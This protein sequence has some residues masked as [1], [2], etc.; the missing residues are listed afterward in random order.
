MAKDETPDGLTD[1][2]TEGEDF[3]AGYPGG[4]LLVDARGAV[5]ATNSKGAAIEALLRRGE[6]EEIADLI[7]EAAEGPAIATAGLALPGANGDILVE[8]T[9][10]P[11]AAADGTLLILVRDRTI[12]HNLRSVLVESRQRFKDLVEISSDFAWEVGPDGTFAFVSPRGALGYEAAELVGRHPEEFVLDAG[13]YSPLPFFCDRPLDEVEMWMRRADG[14]TACVVASCL[15][16]G[17]ESGETFGARG[18]CRDVTGDRERAAALD[19]AR[20]REQLLNHIVGAVRDEV[21]PANMLN[22]AASA[23]GRALNAAGCRIFRRSGTGGFTVA[24]EYGTVAGMGAL[25]AILDERGI[26]EVSFEIDVGGWTVLAAT[27]HYRHAAN[28]A[29]CMWKRSAAG[30]WDD[31]SRILIG[32]VANQLGIANEQINNHERIV[33]LSRTDG[34]TGLLNRRAFYEEELPRRLRRLEHSGETAALFYMDLDNFKAVNDTFGHQRGDEVLLFLR[35]MLIEYSRPG[36]VISRLGGDEFAMWLDGIRPEV[37]VRRAET[38]LQESKAL[39]Q[40]S[41]DRANPLGLSVGIATYDP[42]TAEPLDE[43]L[44]RADAAMYAVKNRGKGGIELAP[45][46]RCDEPDKSGEGKKEEFS[47]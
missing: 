34:L 15:P 33:R 24:A 40:F 28:G 17:S 32:D 16:L 18:V 41:A 11:A 35:D 44:A 46:Y 19:R 39:N 23:T 3:L 29:V 27:T 22:A 8:V 5:L 42:G 47:S 1:I 6:G 9:V 13:E 7:A 25:E 14:T 43:L 38:L 21:E 10:M 36:D 37:T 26:E 20:N 45:S 31:D 30:P 12:E 4:A 2:A